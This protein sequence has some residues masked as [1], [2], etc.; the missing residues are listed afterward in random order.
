LDDV[1][2]RVLDHVERQER[3]FGM[4]I[5]AGVLLEAAFFWGF[6]RLADFSNATHALLF[7]SMAGTYVFLLIGLLA[8]GRQVSRVGQMIVKAIELP[9]PAEKS[10]YTP[11]LGLMDREE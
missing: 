9:P 2:R 8:L 6:I 11:V 1:R 3:R 5:W 4:L 10:D 7:L